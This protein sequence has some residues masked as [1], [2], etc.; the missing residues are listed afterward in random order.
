MDENKQ[1]VIK[2][3]ENNSNN[4]GVLLAVLVQPENSQDQAQA[5]RDAADDFKSFAVSHIH[6]LRKAFEPN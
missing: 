2:Q 6:K 1:A 3:I 4:I 5:I